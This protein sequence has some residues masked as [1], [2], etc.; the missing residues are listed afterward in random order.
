[1]TIV[2]DIAIAVS[3]EIIETRRRRRFRRLTRIHANDDM[4]IVNICHYS[5]QRRR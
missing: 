2:F 1:M 3:Q 5:R 4:S